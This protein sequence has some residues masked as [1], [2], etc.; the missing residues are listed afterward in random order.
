MLVFRKF[1][2]CTKWMVPI[3]M[4][5]NE[6]LVKGGQIQVLFETKYSRVD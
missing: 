6:R 1:C 4:A 3:E 2:D 5:T